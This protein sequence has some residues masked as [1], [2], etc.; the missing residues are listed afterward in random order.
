MEDDEDDDGHE[1]FTGI[2]SF[3]FVR[4]NAP[5]LTR[6]GKRI[7]FGD[8]SNAERDSHDVMV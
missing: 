3:G 4:L 8:Q 2:S 7:F 6:R 5:V 1:L